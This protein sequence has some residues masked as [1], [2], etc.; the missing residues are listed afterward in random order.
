MNARAPGAVLHTAQATHAVE[1]VWQRSILPELHDYIAIPAKSPA[2]DAEWVVNGHLD[3]AV[4]R[5]ADWVLA[6]GVQGL[7]LEVLRLQTSDGRPR[8]P[9][10]FFEVPACDGE[11]GTP[12]PASG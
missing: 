3:R 1:Q 4:H 8:T 12:A 10:L 6:Q 2:F 9:V 5:A 11:D 7:T